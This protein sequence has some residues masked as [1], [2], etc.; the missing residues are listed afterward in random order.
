MKMEMDEE[1]IQEVDEALAIS[2]DI[3]PQTPLHDSVP[4]RHLHGEQGCA[5]SR[6]GS[7]Q[8]KYMHSKFQ[9]VYRTKNRIIF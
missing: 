1:I 3:T 4:L 8:N 5:I 9:S 2:V 6:F 7:N